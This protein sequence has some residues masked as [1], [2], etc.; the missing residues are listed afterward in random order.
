MPNEV[1]KRAKEILATV[2]KTSRTLTTSNNNLAEVMDDLITFEDIT[3]KSVIEDI[4]KVDI[5]TMTPVEAMNL[6][7]ELNNRLK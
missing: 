4:K 1:I 3:E 5:N 2:E 7:F 6:L